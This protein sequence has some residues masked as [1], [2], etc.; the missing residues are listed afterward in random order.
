MSGDREIDQAEMETIAALFISQSAL[1]TLLL[2]N[3]IDSSGMYFLFKLIY[4]VGKTGNQYKSKIE[5]LYL[6]IPRH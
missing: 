6:F 3:G 5:G 1:C 4:P 2:A